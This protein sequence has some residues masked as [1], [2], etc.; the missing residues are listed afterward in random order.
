MSAQTR[1]RKGQRYCDVMGALIRVVLVAA[2]ALLGAG[3]QIAAHEHLA[4]WSHEGLDHPPSAVHASLLE[5]VRYLLQQQ[6]RAQSAS[7]TTFESAPAAVAVGAI[8]L[9]LFAFHLSR[10]WRP[11]RLGIAALVAVLIPAQLALEAQHAPPRTS[12]SS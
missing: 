2:V 8:V 12:F 11:N 3:T 4:G 6:E 1:I 10:V 7:G 5:H 9:A